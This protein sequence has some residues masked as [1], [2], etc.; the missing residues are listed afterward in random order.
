M[1]PTVPYGADPA[2]VIDLHPVA[3]EGPLVAFVHGGAWQSGS[4]HEFD[5]VCAL[6][7]RAGLATATIDYRLSPAV[8]H[9]VHAEDVAHALA[10]LAAH[11]GRPLVVVGHSAGAH[12]AMTIAST[13][14]LLALARP[15][16]FVGLEGIY[17]V[18][19]LAERW[20]GYP[21]WFLEKAF[22]DDA[23]RWPES[24]TPLTEAPWLLVHSEDDE[25]VDAGQRDL[26]ADR[27]RATGVAIQTL[28]PKGKSHDGVVRDLA[29][30]D[31][32]VTRAVIEFANRVSPPR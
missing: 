23:S 31:D 15:V 11:E 4:R 20:P 9:P 27:L 30:L 17:D 16:G 3:G 25:L 12:I 14:N 5:G 26:F 24:G 10:W 28:T 7:Q 6:L 8:R 29:S 18:I 19:Q 1:S 22:G 32:A 13:P 2:Q 21:S